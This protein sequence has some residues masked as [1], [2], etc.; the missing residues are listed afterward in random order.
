MSI[1]LDA[2]Y[3]LGSNLTGVGVYS[4]EMMF[5]LAR[6]HPQQRFRFYYRPHRFF[7]SFSDKLPSTSGRT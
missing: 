1:A 2:T 5:G 3:S 4:R 7:K 6:A